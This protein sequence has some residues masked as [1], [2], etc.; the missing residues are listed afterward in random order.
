VIISK[1]NQALFSCNVVSRCL[2]D[3]RRSTGELPTLR[4]GRMI[5]NTSMKSE[6]AGDAII[7]HFA[8]K[9]FATIFPSERFDEIPTHGSWVEI[10]KDKASWI[11][12]VCGTNALSTNAV[13][14]CA[15]AFPKDVSKYRKSLLLMAAGLRYVHGRKRFTPLTSRFLEYALCD[16][17]MHSVRDENTK[18]HLEEIG[19]KNVLNTSCV[20]MWGLTP[21][22]CARIPRTKADCVL[23]TVTD[24]AQD[25]VKDKVMLE[26]LMKRYKKVYLWLQ[27]AGDRNYVE[28]I[29]DSGRIEM[30]DG[31]FSDLQEFVVG[32]NESI[33]Y[34]GTR[35]HCGIFCLNEGIRSVIVCVDNRALDIHNDTGLPILMRDE[36]PE[37]LNE[38][39]DSSA[40]TK[41]ELPLDSIEAWKGQFVF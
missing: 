15:I 16:D 24:Y 36:V 10:G 1:A 3:S 23:T 31:S 30:I 33:D 14:D 32:R 39:I 21:E 41:I 20:T 40:P 19:I 2:V 9:Q 11:K 18:L 7:M 13:L 25:P 22:A 38:V 35:L 27:G 34:I 6:N 29:V 17:V 5:L 8:K 26:T 28:A 4:S 12:I 37:G